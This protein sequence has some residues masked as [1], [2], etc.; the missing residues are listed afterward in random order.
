MQQPKQKFNLLTTIAMIVGI[1]IGSGIFFRVPSI[2]RTLNGNIGAGVLVFIVASVGIIFGGLTIAR[3]A[4]YSSQDG[5][6]ITFSELTWG[7]TLGY[8][9]GWFQ[10]IIYLPAI[11]AILAWV[12]ANYTAAL[13]GLNNLLIDGTFGNEIWLLTIAYLLIIM[14]LNIFSTINAGKFQSLSMIAKLFALLVLGGAG[15]IFGNPT[16]IVETTL[17]KPITSGNF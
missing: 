13:F 14:T 9:T 15:L 12:A 17:N 16:A 10:T 7:K 3:F 6:I 1:V 2:I 8:I 4:K 11:S 5:G